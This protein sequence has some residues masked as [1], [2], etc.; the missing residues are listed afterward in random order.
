MIKS[1]FLLLLPLFLLPAFCTD[2]QAF[3]NFS[4]T[5]VGLIRTTIDNALSRVQHSLLAK[6]ELPGYIAMQLRG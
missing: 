5:G 6:Q 4:D 2:W 3:G 1:S